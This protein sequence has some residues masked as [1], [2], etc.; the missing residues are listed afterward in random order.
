[1]DEGCKTLMAAQP[2]ET[3][4][5]IAAELCLRA[6]LFEKSQA[7]VRGQGRSLD[8]LDGLQDVEVVTGIQGAGVGSPLDD[9]LDDGFDA[10]RVA[11][12]SN[13][14]DPEP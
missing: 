2:F 14:A 1:M 6:T 11:D 13:G 12:S 10:R 9:T 7:L 4:G 3:D 8:R 5:A